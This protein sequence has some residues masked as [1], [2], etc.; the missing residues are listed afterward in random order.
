[1]KGYEEWS[2]DREGLIAAS[3]GHYD[4]SEFARQIAGDG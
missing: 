3:S 4:A 1:M 2:L